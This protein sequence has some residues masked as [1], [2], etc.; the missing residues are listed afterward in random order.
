VIAV[1]TFLSIII[2]VAVCIGI[3]LTFVVAVVVRISSCITCDLCFVLA[4][5]LIA[6]VTTCYAA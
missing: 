5:L 2:F 4:T 6:R 1:I 3:L